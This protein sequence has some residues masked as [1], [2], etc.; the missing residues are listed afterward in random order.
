MHRVSSQL[1]PPAPAGLP[2]APVPP[3]QRLCMKGPPQPGLLAAEHPCGFPLSDTSFCKHAAPRWLHAA[4]C[5]VP[6]WS[7]LSRPAFF[8][9]GSSGPAPDRR[10]DLKSAGPHGTRD[11]PVF[12]YDFAVS[13]SL[14]PAA[15]GP[16]LPRAAAR[17]RLVQPSSLASHAPA[18]HTGSFLITKAPCP[19]PS[20][21]P[22]WLCLTAKMVSI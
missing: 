9:A 12:S 14:P 21:L 22:H 17:L 16:A 8:L 15:S 6:R 2:A 20:A 7:R 11:D 18:S 3:P 19:E 4:R 5:D 1:A 13:T 10:C